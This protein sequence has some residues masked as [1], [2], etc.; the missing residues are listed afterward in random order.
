MML[1]KI[2][3]L[4]SF[5]Q[6]FLKDKNIAN[7]IIDLLG[8][9]ANKN[10]IEIGP[11]MGAL[12]ELLLARNA[13][14]TAFDLDKRAI[15]YLNA[16][17]KFHCHIALDAVSL[18]NEKNLKIIHSDI[19]NVSLSEYADDKIL[20]IGNIP[21]NITNDIIFWLFE[22][23]N[24]LN[25]AVLTIQREVA[26]RYVAKPKT[27]NYG[28]TTIAMQLYAS[29]KIAFHIPPSAFYPAPKVTSTVLVIDFS[30]QNRYCEIDKKELMQL[31]KAAF[32]QR[33]K[34]IGNAIK[35]YLT[36]KKIDFEKL[37]KQLENDEKNYLKMRAEELTV[38][39]FICFYSVIAQVDTI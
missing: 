3:P 16:K 5:G 19:R 28:I 27:K 34:V 38:E 12:T 2:K 26:E 8:D 39:D 21:Y 24:L 33:R 20:L 4:K 31:I 36:T 37:S 7:K 22:Q 35:S 25:K 9:V 11:G 14:L 10:V 32:S 17:F 1:E 23:N 15:E 29:A 30:A 13:K 6:N 18:F